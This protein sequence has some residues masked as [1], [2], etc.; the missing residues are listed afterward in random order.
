MR[1]IENQY[2]SLLLGMIINFVLFGVTIAMLGSVLPKAIREFHWS[3][4]AAGVVISAA[5]IGYF[6]STFLSGILVQK[7]GPKLVIVI[8]LGMQTIGL[9][10]FAS[11]RLFVL[12]AFLN[13]LIG[14]GQG[15]TEIVAN[16]SV[17]RIE[18][19]GQSRLMSFLHA[20]FSVGAIVGPVIV[21]MIVGQD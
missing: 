17:V 20:A 16:F 15:A 3:Y 2:R 14:L 18:R 10:F 9:L 19:N 13:F 5:A 1:Y 12:N 8:G 6:V 11:S 21:G 4:T 7:L